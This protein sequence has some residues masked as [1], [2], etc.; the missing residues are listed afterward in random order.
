MA[1]LIL[2]PDGVGNSTAMTPFGAAANWDCVNEVVSDDDT[3][4]VF[5]STPTGLDLYAVDNV[6][7]TGVD[8]IQSIRVGIIAK[9]VGTAAN[10]FV[11]IRDGASN[12]DDVDTATSA[13]YVTYYTTPLLEVPGGGGPWTIT[14]LNSLQIGFFVT[15][16][17]SADIRVTQMFLEVTYTNTS[18]FMGGD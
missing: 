2:R 17:T 14:K 5:T 4:Y 10:F 15:A 6:G 3:T 18:L 1:I 12:Y 9:R 11:R 16:I 7:I 13:A 8:Y